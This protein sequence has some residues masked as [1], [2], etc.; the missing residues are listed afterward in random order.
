MMADDRNQGAA[1]GAHGR[2]ALRITDVR[3]GAGAVAG[4]AST[5]ARAL[6]LFVHQSAELYGSDKALLA[7]VET[8]RDSHF[9]PVV[10]VPEPGPLPR[11]LVALG[12][13]TH[14]AEVVKIGRAMY[15]PAG[16]LR[17]PG[18]LRRC[19]CRLDAIVAGRAV[20]VVHS[21][22]LAV[23]GGAL[24]ARRRGVPHLWHVHEIVESPAP[25][26]RAL[27]L[28]V[29]LFA[30]RVVANSRMTAAWLCAAQPALKARC[31]IVHNGIAAPP[32]SAPDAASALRARVGAA[33]D[34]LLVTLAGR[35]NGGKGHATLLEAAAILQRMG[36]LRA[37]H[38]VIAGGPP[39]GKDHFLSELQ[40]T[41]ANSPAR[42]HITWLPF[43]DD[44]WSL[45]YG[46]DIAVVPSTAPES[47]GL[48]AVE[49]MAAGL[50]VIASA[51]G[52]LLEIVDAQTGILIRP[53][54]ARELASALLH[55]ARD[56]A[57]RARLGRAGRLRQ[58]REFSL[59]RHCEKLLAEYLSM[60]KKRRG[61]RHAAP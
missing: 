8:L 21:N 48:V 22:T 35:I 2:G 37:F 15:S 58:R 4:N 28:L 57:L 1:D 59:A 61:I 38:F 46:S 13:E 25:V 42:A 39:P 12:V 45:W 36:A 30:D 9:R 26:A 53:G 55:L 43:V 41:I 3:C 49:A 6:V 29:R 32:P 16:L 31:A 11:A 5:D 47:F 14:I 23:L 60:T 56:A 24:W 33:A 20:Q 52:G 19:R 44:V 50:P 27:P 7:L 10:V 18:A 54:A 17:L 51:Q 40:R 34:A